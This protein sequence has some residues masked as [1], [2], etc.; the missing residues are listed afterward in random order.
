[1]QTPF[2][3]REV[4]KFPPD[5]YFSEPGA[6][7]CRVAPRGGSFLRFAQLELFAHRREMDELLLLANYVCFRE[8]PHLLCPPFGR[9]G[10]ERADGTVEKSDFNSNSQLTSPL[11]SVKEMAAVGPPGR[12][13]SL[14]RCVAKKCAHLV[15]E[16][17]RV[18]YVQG[19]MNS[20]NTLLGGVTLDYG[21]YG[22]IEQ[23]D[24]LYQPF[25]SDRDGKFAFLRQPQAMAMNLKTLGIAC[26]KQ[27]ASVLFF[28]WLCL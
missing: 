24:P 2:G 28:I 22:L 1:M 7:M 18:G 12:Y 11:P 9:S 8:Y 13:I 17:L 25:T 5:R 20:D 3:E 23:Y 6:V 4:D 26:I 15:A 19:N 10:E 14:L 27:C 21:P 16:W